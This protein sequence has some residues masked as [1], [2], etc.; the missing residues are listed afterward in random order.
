MDKVKQEL[1]RMEDLGVITKIEEPTDW[2]SGMVVVPKKKTDKFFGSSSSDSLFGFLQGSKVQTRVGLLMLLCTWIS[3]C[4]IAVTHFLHNQDNVPFLT[5][6]ISE[7]LGEDERLVQGLCALLLGICIYHNDNS[8]ENYTKEKLKQLIEKRIGKENFVEKLGFITKHELYSR[9]ALKPQP[10]FPSPEQM[11]FDHEFT[12]LVKELEGVIT[13]AVHKS[14]EEDK[15]EE[16]VKKTLEQHDNIVTRY[17]EL[18]R[19]QDAQIQELKEQ[20]AALSSQHEQMQA[21]VAQQL[22]QI[23]QHKDQYNI[24]KLKLGQS[25]SNTQKLTL[26]LLQFL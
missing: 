18:I 8:L 7:N 16:E 23:Q 5:A 2:C 25:S 10:V 6:Q 3:N 19:E 14:S 20:V 15:K 22:S 9:A 13:K 12:K 11:L 4:P 21:T 17:K 24:L 26:T 1:S